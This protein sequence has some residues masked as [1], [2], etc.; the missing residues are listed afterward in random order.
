MSL[1]RNIAANYASQLYATLIGILLVPAY[2]KTMGSEAYGLVGFFAML[3]A[4]FNLLDMGLTP[5][6]ARESARY[7]GGALPALDYL[8]T[9]RALSVIFIAIALGGG[10]VL[11]A[12]SNTVADRWLNLGALSRSEAT[13]ALQ[14]MATSVAMRWMGGLYRG[15]VA[16]SERLV[17]L[18]GF[19]AAIATLRFVAVLVSMWVWGFT[20]LVFFWHQC[21]V[22]VIE[23][24]ALLWMCHRLLPRA[25]GTGDPI[26]WSLKPIRPM[27]RF[28]LSIALTSSAWVLVTQS[29]KLLLSGIL[30]L[31]EFGYFSSAVLVA[32]GITLVTSPISS[33]IMPR[34]VKLYA[35]HKVAEVRRVYCSATQ[36]VAI[37]AGAAA[38]TM[39]WCAEPLMFAWTGN[40]DI[41][42]KTASILRLY[43]AGNG[44]L[45][46]S[47]FP[48]YLQ[49]ARGRLRHHLIGN[50]A[51]GLALVPASA[52][53]AMHFG[54]VGAGSVWLGVNAL[55][56]LFWVAYSHRALEPGLHKAWLWDNVL[57]IMLP[58]QL[59]GALSLAV[60]PTSDRSLAL[61]HTACFAVAC[62]A[63]S[64]ACSSVARQS[65]RG[66]WLQ[67]TARG[68]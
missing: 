34:M 42:D 6:I 15:V 25:G 1:K 40:Q 67:R 45:A 5:T 56:L 3:Q 47:A 23:L 44:L 55:Y 68:A 64:V 2:L 35:E 33:S 10:A 26:G 46:I 21:V 12:L 14:I 48:F 61:V 7:K 20:P 13:T 38:T 62:V 43:A 32:G 18:S 53:A 51:M 57:V 36:L 66:L 41:A 37:T 28:S 30:P 11:F 59:L 8:R 54:A 58:P 16:G 52:W 29:D 31:A 27:L 24:L 9:Y 63:I 50:C 22:V 49:Y 65:L 60:V 4:W 39:A 17:W 19:N